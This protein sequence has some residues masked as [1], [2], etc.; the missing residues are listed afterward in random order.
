MI[1]LDM[2]LDPQSNMSLGEKLGQISW[3]LVLL[4]TAVACIGFAM[5]YSAANGNFDPWATRQIMRFAVGLVLMLVVALID[6][7]LWLKFSY[8]L[9]GIAF[10]LLIV[11]EVMGHVGMGAQRWI[12]LGFMQLQPSELM[13]VTLVMAL[14]RYFHGASLEDT[15]RITFLIPALVMIVAPVCLV[16]LQPN[17]GTSLMLLMVSGAIFWLVGVRLWKFALVI[18]SVLA[19]I[20][21]IWHFMHDYQ[22][23]RVNTFLNP[24]ND[25]LG[26]GYHIMQSKIALGSGGMFGKGFL[27]G[28]Q[29]HLNFLPEKQTD[30]I[31]TMLA[32][33]MGM[34]GALVFL[35]MYALLLVYGYVIAMRCRHQYG[36]LVAMGLTVNLFLY[37]FINI[38]MVMGL[39]PVVGVPLPLIS[40][41]GSSA[42]TVMIGFG[43][44]LCV[45]VHRDVRMS[46][47]GM[48]DF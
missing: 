17:L 35:A 39:I 24:E 4:I 31:F 18:G 41:G 46:R 7:R 40:Y 6:I 48:S 12:D 21:V 22:K 9:Y 34:V 1:N 19:A 13:K 25:P 38:A 11:V 23:N 33:E 3:S 30:F 28:S 43:L 32:E 42:L 2:G 8:F 16:L 26:H 5:L 29:S 27:M 47:R 10:F 14:A 44:L 45:H 36:R 15:G 37:M 20:P